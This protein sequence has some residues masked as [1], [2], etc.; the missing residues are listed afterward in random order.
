MILDPIADAS[1][2]S[3]DDGLWQA[4]TTGDGWARSRLIERYL[5]YARSI[6]AKLYLTHRYRHAEF[7]DYLQYARLGLIEAVDRFNPSRGVLFT[8]FATMRIQGAVLNGLEKTSEKNAA[9][10]A[11]DT[12]SPSE[13]ANVA[14]SQD[15]FQQLAAAAL[16]LA[17]GFLIEEDDEE[18]IDIPDSTPRYDTLEMAQ[19]RRRLH[20][21]VTELP[22]K[23]RAVIRCH[24]L[25]QLPFQEVAELM[26]VSRGRISQLHSSGME[27]L[28]RMVRSMH[29]RD[30]A[31]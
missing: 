28:R 4:A 31:W 12:S 26:N 14:G 30:V 11:A 6:S 2:T 13:G 21:M 27:R 15:V 7:D 24:Y 18:V 22:P 19:L 20:V 16:D 1:V 10:A 8:S 17:L 3:P 9:L 5:P 29:G 23:E 25:H